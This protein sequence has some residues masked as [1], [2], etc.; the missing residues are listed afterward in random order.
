MTQAVDKIDFVKGQDWN[1]DRTSLMFIARHGN[2]SILCVLP[3]ITLMD[4]FHTDPSFQTRDKRRATEGIYARHRE[5][6]QDA[7]RD[8]ILAGHADS[9]GELVIR[10]LKEPAARSL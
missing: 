3:F 6:I 5:R 10:S 7:C 4:G 8:L 1:I 9:N 2:D